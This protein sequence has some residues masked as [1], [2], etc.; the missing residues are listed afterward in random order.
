MTPRGLAGE[1]GLRTWERTVEVSSTKNEGRS[2]VNH[3]MHFKSNFPTT[4][5]H[6]PNPGER[7]SVPRGRIS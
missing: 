2:N 5:S 1:W 3:K 4:Y 6:R 7:R